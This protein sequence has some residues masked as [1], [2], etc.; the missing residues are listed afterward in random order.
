[1]KKV[2]IIGRPNVGK[3]TLFN[4]LCRHRR[5]IVGDM[6]GIT[7]DRIYGQAEWQGHRFEVIDTG[8]VVPG[9]SDLIR[10]LILEQASVAIGEADLILLVVNGREGL[11]PLDQEVA[12]LL[13]PAA[14]RVAV[15]VNQL[16]QPSSFGET[17]TF[18]QLGMDGV[19]PLSAEHSLGLTDLLDYIAARTTSGPEGPGAEESAAESAEIRVAIVGRPNVGKSTLL[20]RLVGQRRAIVTPIP[21]TTR[22]SVDSVIEYEG[23]RYRFVD[24]AGIRRKG[25]TSRQIESLGVIMAQKSLKVAD[26][27]LLVLDTPEGATKLDADIAGMAY[28]SGCSVLVIFNKWDLLAKGK[29]EAQKKLEDM[30]RR[31]KFLDFSPALRISAMTG[32]KVKDIY[33]HILRANEGRRLRIS[34]SRLNNQ[35]LPRVR[36]HLL[37]SGRV[38]GLQANFLTQVGVAPPTFVLFLSSKTRLHFSLERYLEN[39]LRQDFVFYATPVRIVQR[40]R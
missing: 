3:S 15:V 31:M 8:G 37:N 6:S 27:A 22:D 39:Q 36:D 23:Q 29:E 13:R 17:A 16:D 12:Q 11:T 10:K 1:M 32:F 25:R 33:H 7:R 26:V 9:D 14:S 38:K 34:T 2:A 24:T 4:K 20:N 30:R 40:T 5:S 19:L 35:F 28:E 21:G 18:Y